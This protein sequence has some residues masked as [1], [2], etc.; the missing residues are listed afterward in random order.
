MKK[1]IGQAPR[2]LKFEMETVVEPR[3]KEPDERPVTKS[4]AIDSV[5]I[6]PFMLRIG[7][8]DENS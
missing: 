1:K 3:G 5:R 8:V 2:K 7:P 6:Q 4:N